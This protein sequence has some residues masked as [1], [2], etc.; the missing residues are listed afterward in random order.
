MVNWFT[1]VLFDVE[2]ERGDTSSRSFDTIM[3]LSTCQLVA[4]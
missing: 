3:N 2:R 1:K 4:V